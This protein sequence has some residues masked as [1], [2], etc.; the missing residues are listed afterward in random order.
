MDTQGIFQALALALNALMPEALVFQ[1][2]IPQGA[3]GQMHIGL[4]S[5]SQRRELG[6]RYHRKV[7]LE[8][9]YFLAERD[10][11]K[12]VAWGETLLDGLRTIE[13][14]DWQLPVL[15]PTISISDDGTYCACLFD[16]ELYFRETGETAEVM[17]K[18]DYSAQ[19]T[20]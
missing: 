8:V 14:A 6:N 19:F 5:V 20:Y 9:R 16:V 17:E 10:D 2:P 7:K 18:L 11:G 15:N 13:G 1:G 12:Y 3:D 4:K